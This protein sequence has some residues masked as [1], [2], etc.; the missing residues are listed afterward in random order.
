M[1][2]TIGLS[3]TLLRVARV[4]R[5]SRMLRLVKSAKG[6][7]T[8]IFSLI[9]SL[10]AMFNIGL[11]LFIA[12]FIY[13]IIGMT[14][15][16]YTKYHAAIDENFNFETFPRSVVVLFQICT[17]A[18]WDSI[19][20]GLTV[21]E[22]CFVGSDERKGKCGNA[23]IAIPFVVTYLMI[24]FIIIVNMYIAII[25]ENF[26]EVK[27]EV[28]HGLTQDDI[29]TF[30]EVWSRFDEEATQYIKCHQLSEFLDQLDPPLRKPIPNYYKIVHLDVTIR[31]DDHIHCADLLSSLAKDYL[32]TSCINEEEE[33]EAIQAS[34]HM[35]QAYAPISSTQKRQRE[36]IACIK[37]QRR[38]RDAARRQSKRRSRLA[39]RSKAAEL[40]GGLAD[41]AEMVTSV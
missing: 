17:S 16:K 4:F 31:E 11:L 27:E 7:R 2:S 3:P 28:Q 14:F 35:V 26:S 8:L 37:L 32:G 25:L 36:I 39:R 40:K 19:L 9:A 41:V 10:P 5:L 33:L 20:A 13:A 1:A 22:D 23:R 29:D 18:G 34:K 38:W 30:Y 12:M 6:I 24:S 21:D 15:F